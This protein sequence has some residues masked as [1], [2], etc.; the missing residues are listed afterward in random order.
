MKKHFVV[1]IPGALGLLIVL[2]LASTVFAQER[3][4]IERQ[5]QQLEQEAQALD[6]N[7]QSTQGEVRT[8]DSEVKTMDAEVKRRQ[9]EIRRLA[10]AVQKTGMQIKQKNDGVTLLT[11]KI[12]TSR[13]ALA[14]SL[15]LLSAHEEDD[16]L[17][18][19]LKHRSLSD[20]FNSVH[21]LERVQSDI[22]DTLTE[23]KDGRTTLE[24]E[25][26]ELEEV[27]EE[28][29]GLQSLQEVER[30]FLAQKKAE[31]DELLRLTKGREAIFQQLLKTKKR[32]IASLKSQLFYLEKTGVTAEDAV[33]LADQAAKRTG[34]RTAFLLALLEVETGKQ[35]E[36]GV[37]TVGTNLGTGNWKRDLYDC[38]INIGKRAS[39]EAE[40]RAFFAITE[41]LGL[42]PDTMPVSRRPN[43]GCGGAMGPAQFLPTTWRR[44]ETRVG[45]LTGHVPPNPW[46]VE[47][48]FTAAALFLADSG[49]ATQTTTGE[50]RAA[51]TYIS[52]SPS[53]TKYICQSYSSRIIS[54]ARDIDKIL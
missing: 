8:L 13:G 14:G 27:R 26:T 34:I 23:F 7:I 4:D 44:F 53:C 50:I 3:S 24:R 28:Q 40:K 2:A 49:A 9:L 29:Q 38:Y 21:S 15:F 48:A 6:K 18:I 19:L 41:G 12:V 35:F 30:R 1:P 39:A 37:I 42:N 11:A 22:Q 17:S 20:F 45:N 54:L 31:K 43:Y 52:G 16:G 47:D 51:K 25:K 46:S 33:A 10:L 32:D 36:D 5:L